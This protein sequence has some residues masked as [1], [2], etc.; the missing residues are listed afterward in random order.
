MNNPENNNRNTAWKSGLIKFLIY[1]VV[2]FLS[3]FL[4]GKLRK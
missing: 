3:A 4:Y 2:G 1:V